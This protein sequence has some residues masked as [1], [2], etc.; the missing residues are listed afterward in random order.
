MILCEVC[1]LALYGSSRLEAPIL[2]QPDADFQSLDAFSIAPDS[3]AEWP[4]S[5][6]EGLPVEC[7]VS[8]NN[9]R[10]A[11]FG[12]NLNAINTI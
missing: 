3:W 9:F 2:F 5:P 10:F 11:T 12:A 4:L 7:A 1:L 6:V 8:S